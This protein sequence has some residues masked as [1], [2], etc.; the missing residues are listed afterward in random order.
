ML[1]SLLLRLPYDV[2]LATRRAGLPVPPGIQRHQ[3]TGLSGS[4]LSGGARLIASRYSLASRRCAERIRAI[5]AI[6]TLAI[7]SGIDNAA[8]TTTKG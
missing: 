2:V 7:T 1:M 4:A 8:H 5:T 3:C 6:E